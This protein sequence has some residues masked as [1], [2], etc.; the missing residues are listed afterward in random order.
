MKHFISSNIYPTTSYHDTVARL[1]DIYQAVN[2]SN[3]FAA[4]FEMITT[5][6][7]LHSTSTPVAAGLINSLKA[8]TTFYY[9]ATGNL[10]Y[11]VNEENSSAS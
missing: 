11:F 4:P 9:P 6:L 8:F 1:I 2:Q 10:Q 7:S 3:A 5:T